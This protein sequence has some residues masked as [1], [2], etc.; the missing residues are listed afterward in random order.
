MRDKDGLAE[1]KRPMQPRCEK[2]SYEWHGLPAGSCPGP[3]TDGDVLDEYV[4]P[5][6]Y[7]RRGKPPSMYDRLTALFED[8]V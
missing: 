6:G 5:A 2:C 3:F 8:H 7:D 4:V 1:P